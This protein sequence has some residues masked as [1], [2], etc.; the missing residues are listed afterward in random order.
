[1]HT[2]VKIVGKQTNKMNTIKI[3]KRIIKYI[4]IWVLINEDKNDKL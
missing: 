1:M 2:I 3:Y 4:Y